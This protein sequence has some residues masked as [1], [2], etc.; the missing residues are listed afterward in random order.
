MSKIKKVITL[1][2][3]KRGKPIEFALYDEEYLDFLGATYEGQ[4]RPI[5]DFDISTLELEYDYDTDS[6]QIY[7]A[8]KVA[9]EEN[10][11]AIE[12]AVHDFLPL[13]V[14]NLSNE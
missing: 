10:L 6:D 3:V 4:D 12:F 9:Y 7:R 8:K 14:G 1:K 5:L 11:Q 2:N 13:L